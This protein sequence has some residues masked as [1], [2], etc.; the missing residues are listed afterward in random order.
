MKKKWICI[1]LIC[2]MIMTVTGCGNA[3]PEM[4][5]EQMTLVTEYAAALL[6]KYDSGYEP[7]LLDDEH[8]AAEEEMQKK[9]EEEA[10]RMEAL[11][12]AQDAAK[13]EQSQSETENSGAEEQETVSVIDP[14]A[15]LEL[16][17]VSVSCNGVEFKESYPD[18]GDDLF[19]AVSASEG[20]KLAVIH[21]EIVNT[22]SAESNVDI[23]NKNAKFKVSFNGGTYHN[24]MMTMLENDFAMYAGTLAP[25]EKADTVLM[26]DLKE[27]EC[28][29]LTNVDLYMK[30]NG[31][32]VK[33][34]IYSQ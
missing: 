13:Q 14:A 8:L 31:E 28:V 26:V 6:L 23:F 24:I 10:A 3:I 7:M 16:D 30:Y 19:F 17:G 29:S 15:F 1:A 9:I 25:G 21:L 27:E 18:S 34:S 2:C 12:E 4:S 11:K 20:C 33:T 32:S 5:D 22:G